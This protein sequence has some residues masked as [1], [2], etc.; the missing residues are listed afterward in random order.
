MGAR[1]LAIA[2]RPQLVAL[3]TGSADPPP[4]R[5]S[6]ARNSGSGPVRVLAV[7][8]LVPWP[9]HVR[10]M[11]RDVLLELL[12]GIMRPLS[13]AVEARGMHVSPG[14]AMAIGEKCVGWAAN[15]LGNERSAARPL[16]KT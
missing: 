15:T 11:D 14:V 10:V 8:L 6:G 7:L 3:V 5:A 4:D 13:Q 12:K 2:F 9:L 1:V 16:E